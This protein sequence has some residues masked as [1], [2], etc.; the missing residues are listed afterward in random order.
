MST[1]DFIEPDF[2]D[3]F[4]YY[5]YYD[6]VDYLTYTYHGIKCIVN[7]KEHKIEISEILGCYQGDVRY[8]ISK[9]GWFGVR[10]GKE[11]LPKN[12]VNRY[13]EVLKE[14]ILEIKY[15]HEEMKTNLLF[16]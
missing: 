12:I 3:K 10:Y 16:N 1:L 6:D 11:A 13:N 14:K 8:Y 15:K 4:T 9:I 5:K 2:F 7:K